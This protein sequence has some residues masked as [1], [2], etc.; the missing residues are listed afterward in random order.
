[1]LCCSVCVADSTLFNNL[2]AA[3]R[4]LKLAPRADPPE[5]FLHH[6]STECGPDI[7]PQKMYHDDVGTVF[8]A[9]PPVSP[10]LSSLRCV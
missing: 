10:R 7:A 3:V 1:M 5:T 6:L 4:E 2:P 8:Q 9:P